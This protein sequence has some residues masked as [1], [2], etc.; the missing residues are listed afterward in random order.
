MDSHLFKAVTLYDTL[1]VFPDGVNSDVDPLLLPKTTLSWSINA[2]VRGGFVRQR[3]PFLNRSIAFPSADIQTAVETGFFQGAGYYRPD[4]GPQQLVAQISGR[5]FAFVLNASGFGV[6]EI[7]IPGDPNDATVKQVW[8]NQA[9]KWLII[10]DGTSKLPIFYDGVTSRRSAG[11]SVVLG[12]VSAG[13]AF[14]NP[15]VI[16]EIITVTTAVA[17]TAGFINP[18]IYHGAFYQPKQTAAAT[19]NVILTAVSVSAASVPAGSALEQSSSFIGQVVTGATNTQYFQGVG[20]VTLTVTVSS[21]SGLLA[22]Q[23]IKIP[24]TT[25]NGASPGNWEAW[26]IVSVDAATNK[27]TVRSVVGFA[28]ST[29]NIVI[30]NGAIIQAG[31]SAPSTILAYTSALFIPPAVGGTVTITLDRLYSGDDGVPIVIGSDQYLISKVSGGPPSTTLFLVNQSDV[32]GGG[33]AIPVGSP[34]GDILSVPELP[35]GRMGAYGLGH[36]ALSLVDGISFIYGDAVGGP[37]GTPANNYRD[38]VLKT[39]ENTFLEGGGTFRIPNSG[40]IITSMKFAAVLDAAYGQ[41]PLQLGTPSSIFTC[42][43]PTDRSLWI[44]LTNPI[45]TQTLIGRGP[46]G[47]NNTIPVNSDTFFRNTDGEGS[48]IF[49]RRDFVTWGNTPISAEMNRVMSRD[50]QTLLS[51]GSAVTFDNRFLGTASPAASSQGTL[52]ASLTD[53]NFDPVSSLRGKAPT[54]WESLWT[55][56]NALQYLTGIFG[57]TE[58]CFAF[59]FNAARPAIELYEVSRELLPGLRGNTYDNEQTPITWEIETASLFNKDVKPNDVMCSLRDGEIA[60][61]NVIGTVRVAVYYKPDQFTCWIPWAQFSVCSDATG[62]PQYFPRLG[63]GEP[64]SAPCIG[65]TKSPARDAYTFQLKVVVIGTCAINRIRLAAST[66][67]TPKFQPPLC[68]E[69]GTC[70]VEACTDPADGSQDA[71]FYS[72][73][74]RVFT[75]EEPLSFLTECPPG[76]VCHPGS[77]PELITYP[78]GRFTLPS[79]IFGG[80]QGPTPSYETFLQLQGCSG[81]VWFKV[82]FGVIDEQLQEAANQVIAAVAAQQAQC[83]VLAILNSQP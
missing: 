58:R 83:D 14:P 39:A 43:V 59:T 44:A 77:I 16:G 56:I 63:F 24:A 11:P 17:W 54:I 25:F 45:L 50:E 26:D 29:P 66:L 21:V 78:A 35:A 23:S 51:Y 37:S 79:P 42:A 80:G 52:H 71:T 47:Q 82:P 70:L 48:M 27:I 36:E 55:G 68:G 2:S 18:V 8:M 30:P 6:T 34:A 31:A 73:Q 33:T 5:L 69:V 76:R 49:G 7:T 53:L 22:G 61:S 46:L 74:S 41:G 62:R 10:T 1:T 67:P 64:S 28:A 72:L 65:S 9:E 38:A 75:N 12:T 20:H 13:A 19:Y 15:R 40:E 57:S 3:P 4:S 60:L 81:F 32:L